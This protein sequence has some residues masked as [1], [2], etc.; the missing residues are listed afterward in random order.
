VAVL[1]ALVNVLL[2][3]LSKLTASR[4]PVLERRPRAI[5]IERL[6]PAAVLEKLPASV[7]IRVAENAVEGRAEKNQQDNENGQAPGG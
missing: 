1:H 4:L 3:V 5:D 2:G 7:R 6:E